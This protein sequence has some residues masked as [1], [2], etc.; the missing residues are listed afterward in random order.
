SGR[1]VSYGY[2]GAGRV[3]NVSVDGV[4]LLYSATYEPFGPANGWLWGNGTKHERSYDRDGRVTAIAFPAETADQQI[5]GY[6]LLDRL[7]SASLAGSAVNL[8]Y[9]Y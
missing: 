9:A 3:V 8:T 1:I 5:F 6:D 7:T 2:D 4:S